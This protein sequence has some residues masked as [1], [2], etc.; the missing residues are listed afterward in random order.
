MKP[1]TSFAPRIAALAVLLLLFIALMPVFAASA[2]AGHGALEAAPLFASLR[3]SASGTPRR[4]I[5]PDGCT[6]SAAPM[7]SK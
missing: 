2:A 4:A 6:S 3:E 1:D 7:R 5:T